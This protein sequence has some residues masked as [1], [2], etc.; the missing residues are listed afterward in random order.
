M[1]ILRINYFETRNMFRI[2]QIFIFQPAYRGWELM[3]FWKAVM[4]NTVQG[5]HF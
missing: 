5:L 2:V 4:L 3:F 1:I